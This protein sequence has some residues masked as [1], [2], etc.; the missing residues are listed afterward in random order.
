MPIGNV[1]R[2]KRC[3]PKLLD[4]RNSIRKV[5]VME[6]RGSAKKGG[7]PAIPPQR[8]RQ[9]NLVIRLN[10]LERE[11]LDRVAEREGMSASETVRY[12]VRRADEELAAKK[13][14]RKR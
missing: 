3:G 11:M 2:W 5:T 7:T 9:R 1:A 10:D 14:T 8:T 13:P 12:L 6:L 4:L